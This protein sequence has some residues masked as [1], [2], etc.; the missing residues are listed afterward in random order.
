MTRSGRSWSA[1][2]EERRLHIPRERIEVH[3]EHLKLVRSSDG[4]YTI[5]LAGSRDVEID[6]K[7]AETGMAMPSGSVITVGVVRS[8]ASS[9]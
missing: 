5:E 3:G 9:V 4:H 1:A 8:I 2:P 6:G 7:P